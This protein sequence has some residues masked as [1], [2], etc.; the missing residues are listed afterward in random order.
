[1][2]RTTRPRTHLVG[3]IVAMAASALTACTTGTTAQPITSAS[4]EPSPPAYSPVDVVSCGET[5]HFDQAPQR[6]VMLNEINAPIL[7]GL[8]V[9]DHVVAAA[10]HKRVADEDQDL[11]DALDA[12]PEMDGEVSSSGGIS[13]TTEAVL[14][15]G[16]DLVITFS[17]K[18]R[19]SLAAVGIPVYVPAGMCPAESASAR[20]SWVDDEIDTMATIFGVT[21]K[22]REL[23]A[24]VAEKLGSL[25][26]AGVGQSAAAV[27]IT[28]GV[29]TLWTYGT[30]SMVQPVFDSNDLRNVY[31]DQTKRVFEVSIEDLL[32][33][34]PDWIV[35]LTLDSTTEEAL[36]AFTSFPGVDGLAAVKNGHVI[37]LPYAMTD[38]ASTLTVDGATYL[39]KELKTHG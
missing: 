14:A 36:A 22:G 28:P 30:V 4:T 35:V 25:T 3:I 13:V 5:L 6:V 19:E 2:T 24:Q 16:A 9:L 23:K 10:G 34:D 39:E 32:A 17:P 26:G 7:H 11:R 12:L 15:V 29:T 21:D 8:D 38:P 37:H 31:A 20:W 1:M 18:S 27:Y 33:K